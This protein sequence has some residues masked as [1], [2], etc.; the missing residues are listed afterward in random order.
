MTILVMGAS[1]SGKSTVAKALAARLD[2]HFIEADDF[3]PPANKE[4]MTA[5]I[6]LEDSD[7]GPWIESIRQ[8]LQQRRYGAEINILACSALKEKL[9][10][11]L[12]GGDPGLKIIFLE[13]DADLLRERLEKRHDH[14]MPASL[15]EP[16]LSALEPPKDAIAIPASAALDAQ[17]A[18][19][20]H[21]LG[22]E[23]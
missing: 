10:E 9:R 12:R 16:Q 23:G 15:V 19:I 6:S 20:G 5:G 4:K 14:F 13:A 8:E 3:H 21:A 2:G 1:G 11:R 7:R 17:I 22:L 18:M